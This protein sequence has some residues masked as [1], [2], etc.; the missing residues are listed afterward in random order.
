MRLEE[1][2]KYNEC[3][4]GKEE[5]QQSREGVWTPPPDRREMSRSGTGAEE[6]LERLVHLREEGQGGEAGGPSELEASQQGRKLLQVP[7]QPG[8]GPGLRL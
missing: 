6:L 8:Q 2:E 5:R 4:E 7:R 3:V 1:G